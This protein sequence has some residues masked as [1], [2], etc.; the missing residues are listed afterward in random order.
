MDKIAVLDFGSQYTQL[1][2]RRVREIGV[3]CELHP[4]DMSDEDIRAFAPRGIIL[5]GG[6]TPENVGEAVR[7]VQPWG[8]DVSSGV[9]RTPGKKDALKV[10]A[11][12]ERARAA[13]PEIERDPDSMPYDW[14]DDDL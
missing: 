6:L 3:Y 2:A 1:I 14:A 9:E 10:K 7:R 8:V 12:I 4:W 13:A 5:A 11:F